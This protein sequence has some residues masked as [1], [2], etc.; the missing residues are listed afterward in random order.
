MDLKID[1]ELMKDFV[2]RAVL[3]SLAPEAREEL[4]VKAIAS[5]FVKSESNSLSKGRSPLDEILAQEATQ[6]C[7]EILR[8]ELDKPENRE[9]VQQAVVAA[10]QKLHAEPDRYDKM[11]TRMADALSEAI[12]ERQYR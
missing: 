1:P 4:L 9:R 3:D 11:V 5:L 8:E 2:R 10:W 12:S 7:R 6:L